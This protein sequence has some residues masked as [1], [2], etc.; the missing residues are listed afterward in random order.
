MTQIVNLPPLTTLTNALVFPAADISDG[1]KTKKVSISQLISLSIGPAGPQ[2]PQGP[3]G[4]QGA[5]GM[6]GPP[7]NQS[8]NTSSSVIFSTVSISNTSTGITFA[9]GTS[10]VTAYRRTVQD[11]IEFSTGNVSLA[12][13]QITASILSGDPNT[14]GRN[15]YLPV[16]GTNVKGLILIVRNRSNLFTFDVW[17]G[18]TNLATIGLNSAVQVACDGYDWF[19]V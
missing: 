10:Q 11:L 15:L 2:G 5:Q 1:N 19:V 17:G 3:Q 8:L 6:Q 4:V 7:A 12:A 16:A 9:D 13:N 18:L 14:N